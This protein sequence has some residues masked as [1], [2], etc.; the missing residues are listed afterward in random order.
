M[1]RKSYSEINIST[2]KNFGLV[3]GAFFA[4]LGTYFYSKN[5]INFLTLF[6]VLSALLVIISFTKPSILKLPNLIWAKIGIIIGLIIS[7]IV[8]F[9]IFSF[10]VTP[11]GILM[12]TLGKDL[13]NEKIE[14]KNKTY[15]IKRTNKMN[16]MK[17]QF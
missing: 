2:E 10:L 13:L 3:F 5:N 7:P 14:R 8:L 9:V 12:R 11:I 1:E 15:W 16:N 17:Q 4:I 6:Y